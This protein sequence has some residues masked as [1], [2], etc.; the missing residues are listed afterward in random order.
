MSFA[1]TNYA[2]KLLI[3]IV[4]LE[5]KKLAFICNWRLS[6]ISITLLKSV[7]LFRKENFGTAVC[8]VLLRESVEHF[9]PF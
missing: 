1:S 6:I 2:R 9:Q 7:S 3:E 8:L 4:F 5:K